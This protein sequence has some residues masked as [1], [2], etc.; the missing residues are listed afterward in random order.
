MSIVSKLTIGYALVPGFR[1]ADIIETETILGSFPTSKVYLASRKTGL[2][3]GKSDFPLI[4]NT[5]FKTCPKLDVLIIGEIPDDR[6]YD[7]ELLDFIEAKAKDA[8]YVLAISNGVLAL[9]KL[10]LL[11]GKKATTDNWHLDALH[12]YGVIPEP[13]RKAVIDGKFYTAGPSTGMMEAGF[14]LLKKIRGKAIASLF[15]LT[16][17]YDP[18]CRYGEAPAKGTIIE[19]PDFPGQRQ[20]LNVVVFTPSGLYIPDIMGAVDVFGTIPDAKIHYVWKEEGE[21]AGLVGPKMVADTSFKDCP[22]ADVFI[23][24]A[25]LPGYCSDPETLAFVADQSAKAKSVISVCAGVLLVGATGQLKNRTAATNF[26]MLKYL[27]VVGARISEKEVVMDGKYITAGPAV[28]SYEAGLLAVEQLLGREVARHIEQ[29]ELEFDPNPV[30]NMGS[31]AKAGKLRT[32]ISKALIAPI[33]PFYKSA[34]K[35]GLRLSESFYH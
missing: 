25:S 21:V 11:R 26:H 2:V 23:V 30:L 28:G 3:K 19:K 20:P 1:A 31:P 17:E 35:K 27:P 13:K 4:A 15:E 14:E 29:T 7:R 18:V 22:Q 16:L 32:A 5:T 9:A 34:T 6:L 33:N 24:G 12:D 10:G 8:K